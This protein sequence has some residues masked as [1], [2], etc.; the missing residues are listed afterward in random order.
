MAV[1]INGSSIKATKI[2]TDYL[3]EGYPY[4]T[5]KEFKVLSIF[6]NPQGAN[7]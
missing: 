7:Y 5:L 2:F 6:L 3:K 1:S 4:D